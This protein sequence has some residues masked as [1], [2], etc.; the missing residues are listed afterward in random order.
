VCFIVL[1]TGSR[2]ILGVKVAEP[3]VKALRERMPN[4]RA[5]IHPST[6]TPKLARCVVNLARATSGSLV[7]DPF[8]GAGSILLEAGDL[9]CRVLG[10]DASSTM[11]RGSLSNL[12]HYQIPFVGLTVCNA[13]RLPFTNV[14]CVVTDPPYGRAASIL[15]HSITDLVSEFLSETMELLP[16]GGFVSLVLQE[17]VNWRRRVRDL[18]YKVVEDH[19]VREHKSLTRELLIIRKP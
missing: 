12:E 5:F 16:K 17:S 19:R 8:C 9:G 6:M 14:D 2:T 10:S 13:I 3:F 18:G 1:L 15:G 11:V 4:R 7:L